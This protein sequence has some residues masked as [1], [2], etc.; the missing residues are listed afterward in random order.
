M[1]GSGVQIDEMTAA[2]Y[3]DVTELWRN[4]EGIGLDADT[5]TRE[6]IAAYL[7]RNPGLSYVARSGG[8]VVG[9]VLCGHDGRRGYLHH[10]AVAAMDRHQGIGRALVAACLA[11]LGQLGIRK[12]N[13]FLFSDNEA[14]KGFW[15]AVGWLE[16]TDLRILQKPTT[17]PQHE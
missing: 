12:C 6:R 16:R 13:I 7:A 8:Q 10:L 1:E 14:G 11:K 17:I 15:K 3:D 2:D 5:D 4:T 9:A